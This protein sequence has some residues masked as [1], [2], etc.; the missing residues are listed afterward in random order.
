MLQTIIQCQALRLVYNTMLYHTL[1]ALSSMLV[2]TRL[3]F[4][5]CVPLRCFLASDHQKIAKNVK[6]INYHLSQT[7]TMQDAASYCL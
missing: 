1:V 7:N 5:P 3:G 4:Y 2:L 6:N